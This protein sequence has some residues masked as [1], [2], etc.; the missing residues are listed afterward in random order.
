MDYEGKSGQTVKCNNCDGNGGLEDGYLEID[1]EVI[2]KMFDD[3]I[4]R[5]MNKPFEGYSSSIMEIPK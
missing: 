4:E 2:V 5:F 1:D 3:A